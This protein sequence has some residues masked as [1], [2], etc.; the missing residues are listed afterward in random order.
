VPLLLPLVP[1]LL[2]VPLLLPLPLPLPLPVSGPPSLALLL[3][4]SE[5][6]AAAHA[7]TPAERIDRVAEI[8]LLDMCFY[9]SAMTN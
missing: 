1:L 6:A 9:L 2:A 4:D 7:T 8:G 3:V 5:Q